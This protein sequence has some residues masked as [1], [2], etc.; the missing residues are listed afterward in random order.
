MH[1]TP[2]VGKKMKNIKI[3]EKKLLNADSNSS[4]MHR[5]Q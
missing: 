3:K 1:V 5:R 4:D 2:V